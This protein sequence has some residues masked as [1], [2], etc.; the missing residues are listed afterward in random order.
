[1][2]RFARWID[3][4]GWRHWPKPFPLKIDAEGF[5]LEV[6]KGATALLP[7]V[8]CMIAKVSVAERYAGGYSFADFI[9]A[10]DGYGLLLFDTTDML[11]FG[12]DG[13][14]STIDAVLVPKGSPLLT[15]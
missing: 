14:L 7:D 6:L 5:E 4:F 10:L 2:R 3:S 8:A 13:H 9:A 11:Q 15:A 1:M 12:R